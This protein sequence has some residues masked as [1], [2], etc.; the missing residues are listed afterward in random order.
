M[1]NLSIIGAASYAGGELIR[2]LCNHGGVNICHLTGNTYAGKCISQVFPY[3]Q[4]FIDTTVEAL[5]DENRAAVIDDSDILF[6]IMPHGEASAM[7][8]EALT[9]G[10]KVIDIGA[11][12]RFDDVQVYERWYKVKHQAPELLEQAVYGLPELYRSQIAQASLVGN[13]GCYPTATILGAYPLLKAG[14]VQQNSLIVDAKSGVSGAGRTPSSTNIY[15]AAAQSIKAYGVAGHRH[16]PEIERIFSAIS[17]KTQLISFTPHLTPMVRGIHS[18]IYGNL[19]RDITG[20]ELTQLYKDTYAGEFFVHVHDHG[21]WPESKWASGSNAC[22]IAVT[23][24]G[25][26]GRFIICSVI[27]NLCKGAAGQAI[28]NMNI[29]FGL[30]EQQGLCLAPMY[31]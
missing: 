5:T 22:H 10:K 11:D 12:F 20:E 28:Q 25:R 18:T 7:A 21:C 27:D 30:P 24:D 29:L 4:G 14:L 6:L 19:T 26:T 9:R 31:P 1:I 13:P 8:K 17:G 23:A 16:T 2:L 15:A 3:L